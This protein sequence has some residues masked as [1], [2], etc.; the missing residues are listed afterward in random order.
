MAATPKKN[1]ATPKDEIFI[2]PL[3]KLVP[4]PLNV[5]KTGG[6]SIE[7]LAASIQAE[8]LLQNLTVIEQTGAKGKTA[9]RY[10]VTA[11]ARRLKALQLLVQRKALKADHDIPCKIVTLDR[12]ISSSLA[13]NTFRRMIEQGKTIDETA[14]A[15]GVS[16]LVVKQRLK[17]ANVSPRLLDLYRADKLRLDSVMAYALTDDHALQEQIYEQLDTWAKNNPHYIKEH[18]T[19]DEISSQDEMARFVGLDAYQAAGGFIR[20]DLFSTDNECWLTDGNLLRRLAN[21]KLG[22]AA[23]KVKK[24]GWGW[25]EIKPD[26]SRSDRLQYSEMTPDVRE[27]TPEEESS[28]QELNNQINAIQEKVD[29]IDWNDDDAQDTED[30]L[31]E[32]QRDLEDAVN[33]LEEKLELPISDEQ[34]A[35]AGCIVTIDERGRTKILRKLV[36]SEKAAATK[37]ETESDAGA[38]D[39]AATPDIS[40]ALTLRLIAQKTVALQACMASQPDVA[41]ATITAHLIGDLLGN[42][43]SHPLT[44]TASSPGLHQADPNIEQSKA[45]ISLQNQLEAIESLIPDEIRN[46][47]ISL[48]Q[49]LIGQGTAITMQILAVAVAHSI[50]AGLPSP[51]YRAD[52]CGNDL[53]PLL[54]LDMHD[55]WRPTVESYFGS[56]SKDLMTT[57]I[58]E[59]AGLKQFHDSSWADATTEIA[60]LKK[61]QAA[62]FTAAKLEGTGWLPE[63]LRT[64]ITE[65][66][67][68]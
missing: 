39:E 32:Q 13:E 23:S 53:A 56:V 1:T 15:F 37:P 6:Q 62:E 25:V 43:C 5:R 40:K 41:L 67:Q 68:A 48:I 24:E 9:G 38:T 18:L 12:A 61:A 66:P 63:I 33:K 22:K 2:I 57:A 29:N 17:L 44:I 54:K 8:G 36:K 51:S 31:L 59:A 50:D 46:N 4:S 42:Y 49:W 14:A 30:K 60:R 20:Q 28:L 34:M 64:T 47:P 65:E 35:K 11:G 3:N 7:D 19:K 45:A 16:E 21:E 52:T 58:K 10:E 27:P 26:L 55:W